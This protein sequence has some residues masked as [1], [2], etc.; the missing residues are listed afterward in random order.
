MIKKKNKFIVI[1]LSQKRLESNCWLQDNLIKVIK[2]GPVS[3]I[4]LNRHVEIALFLVSWSPSF[5]PFV[6]PCLVPFFSSSYFFSRHHPRKNS[7][8]RRLYIETT[9]EETHIRANETNETSNGVR[10]K[11]IRATGNWNLDQ[12]LHQLSEI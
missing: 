11:N 3:E 10:E 2:N 4:E 5:S 7:F 6:L 1:S 12:F 8:I 9:L